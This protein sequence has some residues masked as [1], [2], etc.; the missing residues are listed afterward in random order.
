MMIHLSESRKRKQRETE[1]SFQL[2]F[3]FDPSLSRGRN[4]ISPVRCAYIAVSKK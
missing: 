3:D 4:I 1:G 2:G